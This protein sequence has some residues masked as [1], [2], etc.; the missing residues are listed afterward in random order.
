VQGR[1]PL[2]C[3]AGSSAYAASEVAATW[4]NAVAIPTTDLL[5]YS[6]KDL[7]QL[8]PAFASYGVLVSLVR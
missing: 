5:A 6:R 7:F 8:A 2:I 4:M 1:A 3:G